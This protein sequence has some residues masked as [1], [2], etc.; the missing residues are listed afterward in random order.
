MSISEHAAQ[1]VEPEFDRPSNPGAFADRLTVGSRV[2][3]IYQGNPL[4][5]QVDTVERLGTSF[6]GHIRNA[7]RDLPL[8]R[9]R[10]KDVVAL[11]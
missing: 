7:G 5:V 9:F 2:S 1:I 3:L 11:D 8:I 10:L 6:V 4:A